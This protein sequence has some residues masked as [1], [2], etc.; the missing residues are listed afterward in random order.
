MI[1]T[2]RTGKILKEI[3]TAIGKEA[4]FRPNDCISDGMGGVYITAPGHFAKSE[5]LMGKL[6]YLKASGEV[7]LI[8]DKLTYPNGIAISGNSLYLSE[9]LNGRI[10]KFSIKAP[11]RLGPA[12]QFAKLPQPALPRNNRPDII[13]DLIGPDGI[14]ISSKGKI[15]VAHYGAKEI[16]IYN[17]Q[18]KLTG[19]VHVRPRYVTNLALSPDGDDLIITG[20]ENLTTTLQEGIV[21]RIKLSRLDL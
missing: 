12:M 14:E 17:Q 7:I 19:N 18:G 11:G 2:D 15:F 10:L 13:K 6:F 8:K 21:Y 20:A 3:P 5:Q 16:L 9:H 1:I 4:I